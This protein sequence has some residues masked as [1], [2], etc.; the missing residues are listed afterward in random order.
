MDISIQSPGA[1]Q[2]DVRMCP[3]N[4]IKSERSSFVTAMQECGPGG[5]RSDRGHVKDAARVLRPRS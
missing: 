4:L 5:G 1:G 3:A 2:F